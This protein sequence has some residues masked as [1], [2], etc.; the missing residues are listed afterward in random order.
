MLIIMIHQL[1]YLTSF[2]T[3]YRPNKIKTYLVS[4]INKDD[5]VEFESRVLANPVRVQ[6]TKTTTT[7]ANT[8]FSNSLQTAYRLQVVD[9]MALGL[10][11]GA[12]F[13]NWALATTSADP[14]S[15]DDKA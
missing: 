10:T 13:G 12:A 11:I 7:P 3:K 2:L 5:F 15:I 8:F 9:T 4:N 6:D 1:R 14:N